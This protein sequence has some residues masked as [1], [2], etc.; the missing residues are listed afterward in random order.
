[1]ISINFNFSREYKNFFS[2]YPSLFG[3]VRT[4]ASKRVLQMW[5]ERAL[6]RAPYDTGT[7]KREVKALYT[8]HMLVAGQYLSKDYAL[9]QDVGGKAGRGHSV[10]IKPKH[11]FFK[12]AEESEPDVIRIYEEEVERVIN[13]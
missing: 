12:M 9:I 1:M 5:Q 3:Q 4:R 2:R 7:L 8:N 10:N 6:V 13:G 11:Y